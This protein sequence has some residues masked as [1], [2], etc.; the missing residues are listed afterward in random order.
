MVKALDIVP[1]TLEAD[2][3]V[4]VV[5][6]ANHLIWTN[7]NCVDQGDGAGYSYICHCVLTVHWLSLDVADGGWA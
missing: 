3:V 5:F 1:G 6:D 2:K 7:A 4:E